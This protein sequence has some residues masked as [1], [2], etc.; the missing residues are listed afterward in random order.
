MLKFN[1]IVFTKH[2]AERLQQRLGISVSPDSEYPLPDELVLSAIRPT[3]GQKA[4]QETWVHTQGLFALI[5][6]QSS[7]MVIT[8][9]T[10]EHHQMASILR[11]AK[12]AYH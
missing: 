10:K 6:D 7:R 8:V 11:Q 1:Q 9:L 3:Y 12:R 5:I 4:L 2:A